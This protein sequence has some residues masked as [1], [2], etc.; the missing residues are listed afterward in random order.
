MAMLKRVLNLAETRTRWF[1]Q[2]RELRH[3]ADMTQFEDYV[4]RTQP[5]EFLRYRAMSSSKRTEFRAVVDA[6]GVGLKGLRF[7]DVG[8]AYGD[9][10]DIC[11]EEGAEI[12]SF[13]EI[14]PVFFAYNSLKPYANGVRLNHLLGFNAL[15]PQTYDL[16]WVKGSIKADSFELLDRA[17]HFM[18]RWLRGLETLAAPS[19]QILICPYWDSS[20]GERA[21]DNVHGSPFSTAMRSCGYSALAPIRHHNDD[22][23]YPITFHKEMSRPAAAWATAHPGRGLAAGN[24]QPSPEAGCS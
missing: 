14:D 9:A 17:A 18:A 5:K 21:V 4:A 19:C 20:G 22:V 3:V 2:S 1:L 13:V 10:L 16:I 11:H 23:A 8:P 7:L 24:A 12:V 6:M 15:R